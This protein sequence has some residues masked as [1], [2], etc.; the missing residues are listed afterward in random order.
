METQSA[1]TELKSVSSAE[2]RSTQCQMLSC[3]FLI[4]LG[5]QIHFTIGNSILFN[6]KLLPH[7][8]E[9]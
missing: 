7:G 6:L 8:R 3:N 2:A 5:L 1:L 4:H 9:Q